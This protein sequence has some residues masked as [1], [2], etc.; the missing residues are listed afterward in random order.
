MSSVPLWEIKRRLDDFGVSYAAIEGDRPAL[1]QLLLEQY[2]YEEDESD[3]GGGG[4]HDE[5]GGGDEGGGERRGWAVWLTSWSGT[6]AITAVLMA[7]RFAPAL[8]RYAMSADE[9]SEEYNS[10]ALD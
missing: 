6:A 4:D 7:A 9:E 5:G 1:E 3:D 8:A 2:T 10:A